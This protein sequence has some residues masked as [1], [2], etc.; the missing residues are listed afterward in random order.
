M[1]NSADLS[2]SI[3]TCIGNDVHSGK[4]LNMTLALNCLSTVAGKNMM[5]QLQSTVANFVLLRC[6]SI[7]KQED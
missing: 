5:S 4:E 1:L 3:I 6:V 2:S 7:G